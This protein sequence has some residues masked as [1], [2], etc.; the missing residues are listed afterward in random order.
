MTNIEIACPKCRAQPGERCRRWTR[1]DARTFRSAPTDE[2]HITRV[3]AAGNVTIVRK[4]RR[5]HR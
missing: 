5:A 2:V 4:Y 3:E 1:L